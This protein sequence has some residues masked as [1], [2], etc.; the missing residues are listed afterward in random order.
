LLDGWTNNIIGANY[1]TNIPSNIKYLFLT[2]S[3]Y[4]P[5]PFYNR[6]KF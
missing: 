3:N 5:I 4:Y 6:P 2:R 1:P